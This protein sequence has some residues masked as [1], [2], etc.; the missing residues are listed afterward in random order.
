MA[1]LI[2]RWACRSSFS[3]S[4]AADGWN[5]IEYTSRAEIRGL[6][7]ADTYRVVDPSSADTA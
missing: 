1:R 7:G 3:S 5:L 6:V 4:R 2:R